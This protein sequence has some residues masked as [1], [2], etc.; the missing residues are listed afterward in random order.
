MLGNT[1]FL[2][3]T[4]WLPAQPSDLATPEIAL[5]FAEGDPSRVASGDIGAGFRVNTCTC[6][7]D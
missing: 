4:L 2:R 7:L 6:T 3:V 5:C 1:C